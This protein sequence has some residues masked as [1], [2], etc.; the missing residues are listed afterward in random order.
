MPSQ[1]TTVRIIVTVSF[2]AGLACRYAALDQVTDD[3][4]KFLLPWYDFVQSHGIAS[5]GFTFTNYTPF[6]SYLLVAATALDGVFE[7]WHLI[8]GISFIFE[9]GCALMA[10]RLVVLDQPR[11]YSPSVAFAAVWL[12]PT[13]LFNGAAWGQADA[14]WT[15]F[16]LLSVYFI[17]R[18]K[19]LAGVVSFSVAFSV[20][21]QAIFLSPLIF[22]LVLRRAIHW[23]WLVTIP[24]VYLAVATPAL[25]LGQ[26]LSD[27]LTVYFNQ[28]E[29]FARLSMNAANM[30]L[31][32]PNRFYGAGVA[33]GMIISAAAGL[34]VSII[35]ART[36]NLRKIE[37]L[38]PV[39]ALS[40]ILMPFLL[41]KMHDRYFYAFEVMAIVLAC[42]KPR[43]AAVAVVAQINGVIAYLTYYGIATRLMGLA[44]I[45]NGWIALQLALYSYRKAKDPRAPDAIAF[46][47]T[48]LVGLLPLWAVYL[49]AAS[50]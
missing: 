1:S 23:L 38:V 14:I 7:P 47:S 19:P 31:F 12:A 24:I 50:L 29:T 8:K 3:T 49:L 35:A 16:I 4:T 25:L 2:L 41:P 32:V 27:I 17:S 15:F 28:A 26:P 48:F 44:A 42:L 40:L 43:F 33:A 46:S 13:V 11:I 6:Y 36:E 37:H 20:K 30:W 18:D 34:A 5:L 21:A 22:A 45:G 9:F 39:A 10:M